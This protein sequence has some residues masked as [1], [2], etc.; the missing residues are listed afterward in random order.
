MSDRPITLVLIDEDPIFRLGLVTALMSTNKVQILAQLDSPQAI[1]T[2]FNQALPDIVLLDPLFLENTSQGWI[3]C[4]KIKRNYAGVKI[5]LL[6]ATL[7]YGKLIQARQQG[8]EG[9]F[10]KGTSINA[11]VEGLQDIVAGRICWTDLSFFQSY[12]KVTRK[13]RWLLGIFQSGLAQ[14]DNNIVIINEQFENSQLSQFDIL[15]LEGRK[16]ELR[17]ARWFVQKMMPNKLKLIEQL[18]AEEKLTS[19]P[20][21]SP[22]AKI[23]AVN[24]PANSDLTIES[25]NPSNNI[26][27]FSNTVAKLQAGVNNL[28]DIPLELDI[29]VMEKRQELLILIL[30]QFQNLLTELK[31]LNVTLEQ[32]PDD[33]SLMLVEIWQAS[34]L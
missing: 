32:L 11:L 22:L 6:T 8:I 28:T 34:T 1:D 20:Q 30:N 33:T 14:I 19:S 31:S 15:F 25:I 17:T 27:I 5:C 13:N 7:E 21:V 26:T 3:L 16:R 10:P 18:T 24:P 2:L 9:Y 4:Q 29:L 23:S 12:V